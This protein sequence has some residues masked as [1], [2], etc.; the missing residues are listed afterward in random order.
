MKTFLLRAFLLSAAFL[1]SAVLAHTGAGAAHGFEHGFRHPLGG[2]DHLLAMIAVGI[3]AARLGGRALVVLPLSFI[4]LM[5]VGGA[6]GFAEIRVPYVEVGIALSV[7]ALGLFV[8]FRARM[9]LVAAAVI[10]G[11]FAV[12][13]GHAHG[14]ELPD[15]ES[16]FPYAAGFLAAT[17]LLHAA[18]IAFGISFEKLHTNV[19]AQRYV[20]AGGGAIAL[21][22]V[23]LL[24]R[25]LIA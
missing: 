2:V 12:F 19:S 14:A 1:P 5:A 16:P 8:A 6:I 17:A 9:P 11:A 10:V 25:A 3:F 24:T 23:F 20:Q 4:V 7:V 18:G 22:G 21:A 15:G 13:H